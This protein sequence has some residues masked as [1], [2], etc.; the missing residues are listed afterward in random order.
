MK[1]RKSIVVAIVIVAA[2]A[3]VVVAGNAL[4][5]SGGKKAD[6]RRGGRGDTV[7]SVKTQELK[8]ETLHGYV[9]TNGEVESQN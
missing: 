9:S 3:V 1:I 6:M 7:V 8:V 4:S 2:A 5:D